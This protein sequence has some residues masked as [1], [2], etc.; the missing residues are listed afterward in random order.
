MLKLG[1]RKLAINHMGV[2]YQSRI[3]ISPLFIHFTTITA[4]V[5]NLLSTPDG[6]QIHILFTFCLH[7][8]QIR[9]LRAWKLVLNNN[10]IPEINLIKH[11]MFKRNFDDLIGS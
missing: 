11:K 8:V 6:S 3:K 1:S 5:W 4:G 7:F 2:K 9:V 10:C